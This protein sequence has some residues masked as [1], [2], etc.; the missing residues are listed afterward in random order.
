MI[1]SYHPRQRVAEQQGRA[2][3][4]SRITAATSSVRSCSV[5]P[6]IGLFEPA[7][8]RGCG[9]RDLPVGP[10]QTTVDVVLVLPTVPA[11]GG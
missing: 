5:T 8:P 7:T 3:A 2:I 6:V 10:N 1:G 9:R 4:E 11:V